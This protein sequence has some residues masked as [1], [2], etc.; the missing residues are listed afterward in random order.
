MTPGSPETHL[1]YYYFGHY[2]IA[3]LIRLTGIDPAVGYNL[4][5]ALFFALSVTAIFAVASALYL[6]LRKQAH[7]PAV[8]VAV[9][10]SPPRHSRSAATSQAR[11]TPRPPGPVATFNWLA[12]PG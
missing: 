1:N 10:A 11:S 3:F 9:P 6:A 12:L 5:V 2:V 8:A 7:A 4:A